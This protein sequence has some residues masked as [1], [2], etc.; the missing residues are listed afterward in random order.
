MNPV[1][2]SHDAPAPQSCQR[3]GDFLCLRCLKDPVFILCEDCFGKQHQDWATQCEQSLPGHI[4][5]M[6]FGHYLVFVP[7]FF[8]IAIFLDVQELLFFAV[9]AIL[10][11]VGIWEIYR[12]VM[13][14]SRLSKHHPKRLVRYSRAEQQSIDSIEKFIKLDDTAQSTERDQFIAERDAILK[15]W[16]QRLK[17]DVNSDIELR[18]IPPWL[19]LPFLSGGLLLILS[20]ALDTVAGI[21]IAIYFGQA[22]VRVC[23]HI[24]QSIKE[25]S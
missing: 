25:K 17:E 15:K 10:I 9:P 6:C 24:Y 18:D 5:L 4:A 12:F 8:G 3:C 14:W 13:K 19:S 7:I 20:V 11:G 16:E 23:H 2:A 1:C 22:I 21:L